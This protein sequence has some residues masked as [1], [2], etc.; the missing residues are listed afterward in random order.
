MSKKISLF[1][2]MNATYRLRHEHPGPWS[3]VLESIRQASPQW[4]NI[5][6][7][8]FRKKI[9]LMMK[10]GSLHDPRKQ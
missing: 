7:P 5:S 1:D 9:E 4:Q 8:V 6:A 3:L 10:D 2:L